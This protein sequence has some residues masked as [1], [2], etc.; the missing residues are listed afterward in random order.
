MLGVEPTD[1]GGL[2]PR[3]TY[4]SLRGRTAHTF[5][6]WAL[7]EGPARSTP[8]WVFRPDQLRRIS[9]LGAD[10]NL[11]M[12][13]YGADEPPEISFYGADEPPER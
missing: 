4:N 9:D 13:F 2:S 10:L 7:T 5:W 1:I 8:I 6:Y 3:Y 11:D 12:S